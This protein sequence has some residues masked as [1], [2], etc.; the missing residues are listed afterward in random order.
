MVTCQ[1]C[2][3]ELS[4]SIA[5]CPYCGTET[6]RAAELARAQ[7]HAQAYAQAQAHVQH[8]QRTVEDMSRTSLWALILSVLGFFVCCTPVAIWSLVLG[9]RARATAKAGG[10]VTP[11]AVTVSFLFIGLHALC[12]VS[13]WIWFALDT[14]ARNAR[15]AELQTQIDLHATEANLSHGL[16]C[17]LAEQRL[18]KEGYEGTSGNMIEDFSCDG[19][20]AQDG[21]HAVVDPIRFHTSSSTAVTAKVCL[22]RGARWSV[23][24]ISSGA[25]DKTGIHAKPRAP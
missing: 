12:F 25:C 11:A 9:L 5:K 24:T 22:F 1:R 19:Q 15:I 20:V 7:W 23:R 16:A 21:A 8:Q 2:G 18:L 13:F 4:D 14:H 10:V 3:A 6:P 17:A